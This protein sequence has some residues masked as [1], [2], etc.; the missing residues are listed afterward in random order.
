MSIVDDVKTRYKSGS[1]L[2]RLIYINI[3][4]FVVLRVVGFVSFLATGSS[5][6]FLAL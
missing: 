5:A 3:A 1:L 2:M 4:V 6:N